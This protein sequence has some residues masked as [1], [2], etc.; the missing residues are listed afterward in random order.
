MLI[1]ELITV[2]RKHVQKRLWVISDLQQNRPERATKCMT[3]AVSDFM[4]LELPVDAVCYLGDATEGNNLHFIRKMTEM[5]QRE[6]AR[7]DAPVYYTVG[8]HDFDYFR[9]NCR[10]NGAMCLPFVEYMRQFPQWRLP[11]S[12]SDMAYRV[13]FDEFVAYFLTD[14]AD[15]EGRW[16]TSHGEI[17]G[18]AQAYPYTAEDY[19]NLMNQIREEG[20]SVIT[21][22]HYSFAGGNRAAPLFDRFMPLPDN[23]RMHFYG[24]AHIG[25]HVWA[26]KDC[27]RK[28]S[29]VDGQPIMQ[30]DVA[31]LESGRGSA[32]RSAVVEW[33]DTHEIGVFFRNHLR[34]CWDDLL[35]VREG[36][37]ERTELY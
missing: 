30:V 17:R 9:A 36:E 4:N 3:T 2:M 11:D 34:H 37:G 35:V 5:Q 26:G 22:S 18:N 8:N 15:P 21:F 14:H 16:Y 24:H 27:Y 1:D 29:C 19:R 6:L 32:I 13:D 31:S 28:I 23:L 25:D 12:I 33:Y 10:T 20:K 7:I